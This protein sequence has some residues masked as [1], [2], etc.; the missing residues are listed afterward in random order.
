MR[1]WGLD[2]T[3][4]KDIYITKHMPT[5]RT[6]WKFKTLSEWQNVE[7]L[8]LGIRLDPCITSKQSLGW[9]VVCTLQD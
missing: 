2:L 4:L 8:I 1:E 9:S 5:K 6:Q 7:P 3:Q